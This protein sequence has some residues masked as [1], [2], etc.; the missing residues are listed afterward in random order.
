MAT[1]WQVT[2]QRQTDVLTPQGTFETVMEVNFQ[3]IPEGITGQVS[4]P[5]RVYEADYVASQ[6]DNRVAAIKAVQSL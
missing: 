5:L 1:D 2:A 6:I 4:I 3:T